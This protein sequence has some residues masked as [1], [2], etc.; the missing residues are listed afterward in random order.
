MYYAQKFNLNPADRIVVPIFQT[1]I[2]K[3]HAIYLG[4]GLYGYEWIAENHA[5]QGVRIITAEQYFN[6]HPKISR[7]ERFIGNSYQRKIAIENAQ[8]LKGKQYDLFKYNCEH[9]AN[10]IQHGQAQ[11]GQ[12]SGFFILASLFVFG[13]LIAAK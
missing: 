3:H 6:E 12:V 7:I 9:Y 2:T 4:L 11:S 1:G 13:C 5:N 10:E 8:N